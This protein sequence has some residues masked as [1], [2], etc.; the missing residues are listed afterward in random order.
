MYAG[1]IATTLATVPNGIVHESLTWDGLRFV[2]STMATAEMLY[3][4]LTVTNTSGAPR[5]VV[6]GN[7]AC[8]IVLSVYTSPD[9]R[10]PAAYNGQA[11]VPNACDLRSEPY[12]LRPGESRTI[13]GAPVPIRAIVANGSQPE[14]CYFTET[15]TAGLPDVTILGAGQGLIEPDRTA[16]P[17]R[18]REL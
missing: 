5:R 17:V 6:L 10:G 14:M 2:A 4:T 13:V 12:Q 7:P 9:R 15:V 11:A 18:E 8:T 1:A 3:P 16:L